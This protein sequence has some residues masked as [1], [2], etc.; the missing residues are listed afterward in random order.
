MI[1]CMC[2]GI[3]TLL[4]FKSPIIL[5]FTNLI[6]KSWHCI[7]DVICTS[8]TLNERSCFH[9]LLKLISVNC[10]FM[11]FFCCFSIGLFCLIDLYVR[12]LNVTKISP[13][14]HVANF[15]FLYTFQ[16]CIWYLNFFCYHLC[17]NFKLYD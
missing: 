4:I 3:S 6:G 16:L 14:S 1:L 5:I 10:S 7:V 15:S 9:S 12:V 13:L 17:K 8:L 11:S 2:M